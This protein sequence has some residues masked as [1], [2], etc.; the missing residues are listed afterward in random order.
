MCGTVTKISFLNHDHKIETY[1]V[2]ELR[3]ITH[4]HSNRLDF[5]A[6]LAEQTKGRGLDSHRGHAG[7][8]FTLPMKCGYT[9]RV[10]P[11]S[12]IISYKKQYRAV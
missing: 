3:N 9:L 6:E 8:F 11:Q 4:E 1:T 12:Q 2:I 5:V 10:T 7:R